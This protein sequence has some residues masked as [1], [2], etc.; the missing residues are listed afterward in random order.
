M[1]GT[2]I[3]GVSA[4]ESANPRKVNRIAAT[5]NFESFILTLRVNRLFPLL[6]KMCFYV[7]FSFICSPS[8]SWAC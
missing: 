5:M 4:G 3:V 2:D 7:L 6:S 1:T 8:L